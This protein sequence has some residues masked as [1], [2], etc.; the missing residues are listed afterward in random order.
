MSL[1]WITFLGESLP[2]RQ[3]LHRLLCTKPPVIATYPGRTES[4]PPQLLGPQVALVL[5]LVLVPVLVPVPVPV[6]VRVVKQP[7]LFRQNVTPRQCPS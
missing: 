6:L 4:C 3:V 5:V 1:A 7:C 2:H